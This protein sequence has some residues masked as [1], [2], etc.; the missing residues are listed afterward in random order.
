[1]NPVCF[2]LKSMLSQ[3]TSVWEQVDTQ[4][5]HRKRRVRTRRKQG[6][7][8]GRLHAFPCQHYFLARACGP[9]RKALDAGPGTMTDLLTTSPE[10]TKGNG[11]KRHVKNFSQ[12]AVPSAARRPPFKKDARKNHGWANYK[13]THRPLFVCRMAHDAYALVSP[14]LQKE[15]AYFPQTG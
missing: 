13:V 15:K 2:P 4:G 14:V 8:K 1:M 9:E 10:R 12:S 7:L 11:K 6:A 3:T 5:S